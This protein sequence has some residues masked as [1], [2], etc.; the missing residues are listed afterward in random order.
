[1]VLLALLQEG[2][3]LAHQGVEQDHAGLSAGQL[4]CGVEGL[5]HGGQV[6]AV[7]P[8][9]MPAEGGP[10]V[11]ERLETQHLAGGAVRLLVVDIDEADEV[12]QPLVG[13]GH[14]RLPSGTFVE[15][16][17]GH[18]VVDEGRVA[19]VAKPQSH[20]HRDR[21]ALAQR[22]A[23]H[24]HAR[25]VGRHAG[26]G[27]TAVVAAVG[28]QL[29]LGD[30]AGFDQRRIESDRVVPVR[31]QEAVA[32][33]P[34]GLVRSQAQRVAIGHCQHIGPAQGLADVAL[35]LDLTH[36]QGVAPDPVGAPGQ[37]GQCLGGCIHWEF[38]LRI[39]GR[40]HLKM[41]AGT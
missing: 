34:F 41:A 13:G 32:A 40:A 30:D 11:G 4:A 15:L 6:V 3:A 17:V 33:F 26:H 18:R 38:S 31:K 39:G 7:D 25:R 37:L 36:A 14:G 16:A 20:A 2:H 21:Q 19:L 22:A 5:Q 10:L 27:Q 29:A 1:V 12:A 28:L 9:H 24:L 35:A 8:L 23:G